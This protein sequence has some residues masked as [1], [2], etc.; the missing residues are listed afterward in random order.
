M[1]G[2]QGIRE[3]V[4]FAENVLARLKNDISKEST[5]R[6]SKATTDQLVAMA[7]RVEALLQ[8]VAGG[9]LVSRGG[10]YCGIARFAVED[11][12]AGDPL[13]DDLIKVGH[14]FNEL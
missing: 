8:S 2:D 12:P 14:W 11:W 6:V 1:Q 7:S 5:T 10:P 13:A 3:F 9:N 4:G